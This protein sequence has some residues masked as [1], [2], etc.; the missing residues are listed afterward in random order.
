MKKL[1]PSIV[2]HVGKINHPLSPYLFICFFLFAGNLIYSQA[3]GCPNVYAGEDVVLDC[4]EPCVELTATFLDTGETTD[5]EVSAIPYNPPFPF[6][7]GTSVSVNIDDRWSDIIP[8][9]FDFCFY[10]QTLI[11][12]F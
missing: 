10:G 8:L 4:D 11:Q 9:P 3:P 2:K 1:L 7:G 5:Y 6:T 12:I